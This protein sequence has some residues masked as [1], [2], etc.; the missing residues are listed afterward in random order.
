MLFDTSL[1]LVS[2]CVVPGQKYKWRERG[3]WAIPQHQACGHFSVC[4]SFSNRRVNQGT[5]L[6]LIGRDDMYSH[7]T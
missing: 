7:F 5:V 1:L 6:Q 2:A 4:Y 3:V